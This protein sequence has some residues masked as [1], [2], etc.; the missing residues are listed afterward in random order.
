[1]RRTPL[2][3]LGILVV[4]GVLGLV[5]LA[6]AKS[7]SKKS[8]TAT[9]TGATI[10][11]KGANYVAAY[12]IHSSADGNGAGVQKGTIS[13]SKFPL[14]GKATQTEY[15]KNATLVLKATFKIGTLNSREI[16]PL[17]G[18][19]SCLTGT[20]ADKGETCKFTITGMYNEKTTVASLKLKG[21]YEK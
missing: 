8:F 16:A 1:M 2:V 5:G 13:G 12:A 17:S 15:F 4:A 10:Q 20:G 21:T 14:T 19:G 18:S 6:G 3:L 7:G 9:A 11:S